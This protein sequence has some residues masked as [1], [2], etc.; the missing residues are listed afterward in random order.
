MRG[1]VSSKQF[2][3]LLLR[4]GVASPDHNTIF[5]GPEHA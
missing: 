1:P 2:M 4:Y 5:V 3:G